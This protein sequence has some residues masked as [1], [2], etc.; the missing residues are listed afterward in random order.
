MDKERFLKRL[1]GKTNSL[2]KTVKHAEQFKEKVSEEEKAE[3][4]KIIIELK[5]IIFKQEKCLETGNIDAYMSINEIEI[6]VLAEF[7]TI[8]S[9]H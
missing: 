5:D 3:L 2:K 1:Q 8:I 4:E 9:K 6:G 7:Y